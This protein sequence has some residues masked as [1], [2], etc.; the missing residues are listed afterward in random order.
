[1][2]RADERYFRGT[3]LTVLPYSRLTGWV[4]VCP[5]DGGLYD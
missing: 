2:C 4:H 1:M 5:P 3:N